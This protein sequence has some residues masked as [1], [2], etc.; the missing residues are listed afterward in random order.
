MNALMRQAS[1]GLMDIALKSVVKRPGMVNLVRPLVKA[2]ASSD[3]RREQTDKVFDNLKPGNKFY[4]IAERVGALNDR[5]RNGLLRNFGLKAL[6]ARPTLDVGDNERVTTP[7][8][9][10]IFP[11]MRCNLTCD[12]CYAPYDKTS[13]M[14][15][16]MLHRLLREA[17]DFKSSFLCIAGGEPTLYKGLFETF[18]QYPDLYFLVFTNG[19]ALDDKALDVIDRSGNV[20]P[21]FGLDGLGDVTTERRSKRTWENF[22][23][24]TRKM[25][26]R[27]MAF[28]FSCHV[29]RRNFDEAFSEKFVQVMAD[30]GALCGW[31]S[32]HIPKDKSD[33]DELV[34]TP[35]QRIDALSRIEQLRERFPLIL[36]DS[37]TDPRY[38]G[39]CPAG[40]Y[41]FLHIDN[42]GNI[43][44]CPFI[45][46]PVGNLTRMTLQEAIA[47]R[48]F[49]SVRQLGRMNAPRDHVAGCIALDKHDQLIDISRLD[50]QAQA[51]GVQPLAEKWEPMRERFQQYQRELD[52]YIEKNVELR[53][54]P[55]KVKE[56]TETS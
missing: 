36:V 53:R 48:Y 9:L 46:Y 47:S 11:T 12:Y 55:D 44:P 24:T 17:T 20:M 13:D 45:P 40:G 4:R 14:P 1:I 22:L 32:H 27:G 2:C 15:E 8:V 42:R 21:I 28:G 23:E 51:A 34:L 50:K 19:L 5:A 38:Q 26:E 37:A 54:S 29:D 25:R 10:S 39:G 16:E 33:F 7:Q 52:D 41:T 18:A 43:C 31:F 3:L 30:S 35:E 56:T 49:K 6:A